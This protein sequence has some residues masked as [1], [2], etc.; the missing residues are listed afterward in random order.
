VTAART[1]LKTVLIPLRWLAVDMTYLTRLTR[2][3]F[4]ES[5][6]RASHRTMGTSGGRLSTILMSSGSN[7]AAPSK[8]LT[9]MMNGVPLR[10]K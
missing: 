10:S 9:A 5:R 1:R 4:T 3:F 8:Q 7:L 2:T 6:F